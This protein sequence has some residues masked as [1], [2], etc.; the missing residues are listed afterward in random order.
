AIRIGYDEAIALAKYLQID[1]K[2]VFSIQP[3]D[4]VEFS[5][6]DLDI[7]K[8]IDDE[9]NQYQ[10]LIGQIESQIESEDIGTAAF[11]VLQHLLDESNNSEEFADKNEIT[12]I[13]I[14]NFPDLQYILSQKQIPQKNHDAFSHHSKRISNNQNL[15]NTSSLNLNNANKLITVLTNNFDIQ[16]NRVNRRKDHWKGYKRLAT[17]PITAGINIYNI[18]DANVSDFH[19]LIPGGYLFIY[20]DKKLCIAQIIQYMK[21]G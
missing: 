10:N 15:S 13:S 9:N 1:N 14:A 17:I 5:S 6:D 2:T 8:M 19:P 3:L 4:H 12:N 11:E 18:I 20:S 16:E 21:S 7:S